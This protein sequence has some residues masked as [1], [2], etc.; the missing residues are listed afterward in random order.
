VMAAIANDG[1]LVTPHLAANAGPTS[2]DESESISGSLQRTESRRING[3]HRD[4]LDR[5]REGLT[6]VVNDPHGT[7]YKK[8]RMKEVTIAGKTGTAQTGGVDHAWFAG[9]VPAERPR[10]AFLVVLEHGGGGGAAA[11][12]V[13]HE[14]VKM[15]V[16][17]GLVPRTT[18]LAADRVR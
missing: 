16:E 1:Y 4:T 11:G 13:A 5:I 12:P 8:V 17:R 7:G 18:E 10:I 3:L 2:M 9:Y 14:F 15:L 6:M